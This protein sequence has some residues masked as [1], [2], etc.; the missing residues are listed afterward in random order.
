MV[1]QEQ[2]PPYSKNQ[3]D[4]PGSPEIAKFSA[5]I[6]RPPRNQ[7]KRSDSPQPLPVL[8]IKDMQTS[9]KKGDSGKVKEVPPLKIKNPGTSKSPA[10]TKSSSSASSKSMAVDKQQSQQHQGSSKLPTSPKS[11]S[12][13]PSSTPK[14]QEEKKSPGMDMYSMF[15]LSFVSTGSI[16]VEVPVDVIY[17]AVS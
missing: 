7:Q 10:T 4:Q 16:P 15:V 11:S 6:T 14:A 3:E 9:S 12:N 1:K 13:K 2:D 17:T 5:L 8:K